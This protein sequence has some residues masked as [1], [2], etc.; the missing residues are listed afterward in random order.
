MSRSRGAA[1]RSGDGLKEKA[2]PRG[3]AEKRSITNGQKQSEQRAK[4][5]KSQRAKEPKSQ[6]VKGGFNQRGN[7]NHE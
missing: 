3:K 1:R 4:E 5:S 2:G 6:R 7:A